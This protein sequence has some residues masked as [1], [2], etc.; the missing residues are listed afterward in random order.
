[1]TGC[2]AELIIFPLLQNVSKG[3]Q[4]GKGDRERERYLE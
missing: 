3:K 4:Q 2:C 1:L